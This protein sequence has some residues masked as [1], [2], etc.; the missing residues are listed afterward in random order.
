MDGDGNLRQQGI[1]VSDAERERTVKL[2]ERHHADGR[3]T[4]EEFSERM[5]AAYHSRTREELRR[6]LTD[7]PPLD[8]PR[9]PAGRS[10]PA[11]PWWRSWLA[12]PVIIAALIALAI[13]AW[14]FG[15]G[16]GPYHRGFFPVFPLLFWGFILAR[17]ILPRRR[18]WW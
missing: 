13:V 9:P 1:R 18:R 2:L 11:A 5:E 10:A 7:L 16:P 12:P 3:L 4:W 15:D 8:E 17:F 6:T 14:A